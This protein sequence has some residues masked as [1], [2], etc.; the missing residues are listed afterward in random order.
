MDITD[1]KENM[2]M[3]NDIIYF[4]KNEYLREKTSDA[5]IINQ[6]I[7]QAENVLKENNDRDDQYF[8]YGTLGNLYRINEKPKKAITYLTYC[9]NQ[10]ID[11]GNP[12]KEIVSFIRLGEAFKYDNNHG[13]AMDCFNKALEMCEM[14]HVDEYL[15][16]ALQHKGKCLIELT[17]LKEADECFQKALV[18]RKLKGNGTLIESTEQA[19]E[20]LR[21]M[22]NK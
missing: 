2:N 14:Y 17:R 16:F 11:E 1:I 7:N 13:K 19:I 20:L 21:E 3:I 12:T 8:L 4:D 6:V 18:L 5:I 10:A 9:L 15:D 22:D